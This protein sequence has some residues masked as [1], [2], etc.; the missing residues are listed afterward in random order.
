[1]FHLVDKPIGVSSFSAAARTRRALKAG[2]AGHTGTLDP[3]ASGLLIIA[4]NGSTKLIPY[5]EG[6]RKTYRFTVDFSKTSESLD[7]GT[8]TADIDAAELEAA[9][10]QMSDGGLEKALDKFR[11]KI[12]QV[13]PKYSALRIDGKRAYRLAR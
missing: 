1:M 8:E 12:R 7:L 6:D 13:P 5:F 11:G 10:K 3:L 2:K 9:K 4:T